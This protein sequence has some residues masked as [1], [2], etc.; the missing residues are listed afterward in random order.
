MACFYPLKGWRSRTP[1]K[2][3]KYPIVFNLDD[4]YADRPVEVACGQCTGCRLEHS[5]QWA[6]RCVHEAKLYDDNSFITLTYNDENLPKD[7]SVDIQHFQKFIKKLRKRFGSGIR[8][9]HCGEYGENFNR[10]HY[11]ALLFNFN[12]GD[13]RLH[14]VS[15]GHRLYTS[16]TLDECWNHR[17]YVFVGDVTFQ[18]AA[19][20]ARYVMKK[21]TGDRAKE[22]YKGRKPEYISMSRRPGIGRD[23][24]AQ[25]HQE[26]YRD[27]FIVLDGKKH[28]IP[29]YYDKQQELIDP[30]RLSDIKFNRQLKAAAHSENNSEE[31]LIVRDT[32]QK[33]RASRLIRSYENA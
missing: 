22:H 5:R 32:C 16:T 28:R 7:G 9:F 13:R 33:L 29:R 11:H 30:D 18:S 26:M 3:G 8:Y 19:Y 31:R 20:V 15:G 24:F 14:S 1:S 10:P 17:G 21:V 6:L 12:P 4:A 25:Y 27:D 2:N 23:F